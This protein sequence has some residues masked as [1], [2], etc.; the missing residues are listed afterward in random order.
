VILRAINQ[1]SEGKIISETDNPIKFVNLKLPKS[2]ESTITYDAGDY[3]CNFSMYVSCEYCEQ[4]NVKY[5][6]LHIPLNSST[7]QVIR[8]LQEQ[9]NNLEN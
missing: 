2:P 6:F 9:L 3:V 8:F 5:A 4:H 1:T 7:D